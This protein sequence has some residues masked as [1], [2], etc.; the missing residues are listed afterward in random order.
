MTYVVCYVLVEY[1][2]E[3]NFYVL[4]YMDWGQRQWV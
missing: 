1:E 4:N 3:N 2:L